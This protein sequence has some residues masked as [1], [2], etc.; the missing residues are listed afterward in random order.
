MKI[1]TEIDTMMLEL[2]RNGTAPRYLVIGINQFERLVLEVAD[3]GQDIKNSMQ[4]MGCDIIIT[5]SDIIELAA[6]AATQMRRL[7]GRH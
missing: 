2:T 3:K 4:Y 1:A 6:D 7:S 5:Q